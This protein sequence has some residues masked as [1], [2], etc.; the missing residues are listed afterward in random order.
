MTKYKSIERKNPSI[1]NTPNKNTK[2]VIKIESLAKT[3]DKAVEEM[4]PSKRLPDI[5]KILAL[6]GGNALSSAVGEGINRYVIAKFFPNLDSS[7]GGILS[8]LGSSI[9]LTMVFRSIKGK[10]TEYL[11]LGTTQA[12][13]EPIVKKIWEALTGFVKNNLGTK[14][15]TKEVSQ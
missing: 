9:L 13:V 11:A 6:T 3:A 15:D 14:T 5:F 2:E 10:Y 1:S 12:W 7:V 4:K 8:K